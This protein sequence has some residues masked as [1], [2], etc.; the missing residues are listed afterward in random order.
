M[1]PNWLKRF[2]PPLQYRRLCE[3]A[4]LLKTLKHKWQ[5]NQTEKPRIVIKTPRHRQSGQW[6]SSV[7]CVVS[8]VT[9]VT[10]VY[11]NASDHDLLPARSVFPQDL[12]DVRLNSFTALERFTCVTLSTGCCCRLM[13][14]LLCRLNRWR[15]IS[16]PFDV[17][18]SVLSPYRTV[19]GVKS[20]ILGITEGLSCFICYKSIP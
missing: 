18:L 7:Q 5:L 12:Q 4:Q 10:K 17:C 16:M 11:S 2:F 1:V 14:D 15:I 20:H 13:C 6:R 9:L 19:D 3:E 8:V